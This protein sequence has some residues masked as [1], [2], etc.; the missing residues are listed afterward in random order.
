M[1]VSKVFKALL[2]FFFFLN[3][4]ASS[5]AQYTFLF[6]SPLGNFGS[7]VIYTDV[8]VIR[9]NKWN[10]TNSGKSAGKGSSPDPEVFK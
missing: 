5:K 10:K 6:I 7:D 9:N 3:N 4:I 8:R 1:K 2:G